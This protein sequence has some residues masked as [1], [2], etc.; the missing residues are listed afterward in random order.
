MKQMLGGPCPQKSLG[1]L[2][3]KDRNR[4]T[5]LS[6]YQDTLNPVGIKVS[7][8]FLA[9]KLALHNETLHRDSTWH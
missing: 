9:A 5:C 1:Y 6:S 2:K 7:R 8:A 4:C 3:T